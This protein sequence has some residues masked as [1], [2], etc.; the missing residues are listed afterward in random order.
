MNLAFI[1]QRQDWHDARAA[2]NRKLEVLDLL[3]I[4]GE[5]GD[6]LLGARFIGADPAAIGSALLEAIDAHLD[7]VADWA[8]DRGESVRPTPEVAAR[9]ALLRASIARVPA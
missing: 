2:A 6:Q 9:V 7:R 1:D 5:I 4:V 8:V 3:E